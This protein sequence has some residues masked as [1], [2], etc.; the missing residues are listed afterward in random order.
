MVLPLQ[1]GPFQMAWPSQLHGSQMEVDAFGTSQMVAAALVPD[2]AFG[3]GPLGSGTRD[4]AAGAADV[5][6]A[7][8]VETV[9]LDPGD[10]FG[11]DLGSGGREDRGTAAQPSQ[12]KSP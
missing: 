10:A 1:L 7:S 12:M 4:D 3:G 9:D 5:L 6:G 2:D 8:L 11:E